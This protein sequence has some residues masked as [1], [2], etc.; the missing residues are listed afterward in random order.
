VCKGEIKKKCDEEQREDG[1]ERKGKN[2]LLI[3]YSAR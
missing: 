2:A 1:R 3:V